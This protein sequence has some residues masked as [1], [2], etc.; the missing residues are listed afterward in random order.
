MAKTVILRGNARSAKVRVSAPPAVAGFRPAA[1]AVAV[2]AAFSFQPGS[3]FAQPAGAQAIHGSATLQ[4][5]GANL[6]V[7]TQNGAGS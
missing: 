1:A 4:R 2:A 5:N 6:L 3:L 7:T